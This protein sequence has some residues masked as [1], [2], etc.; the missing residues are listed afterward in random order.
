M[1][2]FR[3]SPRVSSSFDGQSGI[4]VIC[5]LLKATHHGATW[6][7]HMGSTE[8]TEDGPLGSEDDQQPPCSDNAA[9]GVGRAWTLRVA[10]D[11]IRQYAKCAAL[12]L[13]VTGHA[14]DQLKCRDILTGDVLHVLKRGFVV[15]NPRP[16]TNPDLFKYRMESTSPNSNGRTIGVVVIP[17]TVRP[18][19]KIVTVMWVD[20]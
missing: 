18:S 14:R 20:E 13:H 11:T 7:A 12:D 19:I 10:T 1:H 16:S 3:A 9:T 15:T 4:M 2:E 5:F 17:S 8:G 6:G